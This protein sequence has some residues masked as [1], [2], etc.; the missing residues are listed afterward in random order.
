MRLYREAG[1]QVIVMSGRE[2]SAREDTA[3]WL[4]RC[5]VPF[6]LLLMRPTVARGQSQPPD[7][8]MKLALYR[9][10]VEGRDAVQAV[11]DDRLKVARMW[12]SLGLPLFRV[13]DPD[14]DF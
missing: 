8:D 14:A 5:R 7:Q 4:R 6:D 9:A 13:G 1:Y 10:H 12:H 2:D 3:L 11:F